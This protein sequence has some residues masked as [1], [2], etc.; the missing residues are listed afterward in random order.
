[1]SVER[2]SV[3][4]ADLDALL[5]RLAEAEAKAMEAEQRAAALAASIRSTKAGPTLPTLSA[6]TVP[7]VTARHVG[8]GW[9]HR[10]I[11]P[12]DHPMAAHIRELTT[13][14]DLPGPYR[15]LGRAGR[16][17]GRPTRCTAMVGIII[18]PDGSVVCDYTTDSAS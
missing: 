15:Y 18:E 12:S 4:R 11:L 17:E 3:T 6:S 5:A 7:A 10:H 8:D 13:A 1:M 2:K 14:L 16:G 9:V